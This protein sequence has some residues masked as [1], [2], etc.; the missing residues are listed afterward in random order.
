MKNPVGITK[1]IDMN[2]WTRKGLMERFFKKPS[3]KVFLVEDNKLFLQTL[4]VSM[5]KE[6]GS[7][8]EISAY[9]ESKSLVERMDEFPN[10]LVMDYHLDSAS[11]IEGIELVKYVRLKSPST[12]IIVLTGEDDVQKALE[13]YKNGVTNYIKKDFTAVN[14]LMKEI[15]YK[16]D[17]SATG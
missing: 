16:K 15:V 3:F 1:P 17:L 5:V 4:K 7:D 8:I 11:D 14:R 6:F 12:E 9:T 2:Y 13:C 10:V